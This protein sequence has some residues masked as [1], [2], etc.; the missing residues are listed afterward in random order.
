MSYNARKIEEKWQSYWSE[1]EVYRVLLDESKPKYY[2]LDMFPY[3]SGAGLHVGHP[4]GYIA[5]DIFARYKRHKG[6]NVLHPMGFD[7]F[8]LPAE[9]YAI[10]TGIHPQESTERNIKRYKEQLKSIGFSFDWSREVRTSDPDFYKW[11]QWIFTQMFAHYYD[12][13]EDKAKPLTD[14]I[15]YFDTHGNIGHTAFTEDATAFSAQ[16]WKAFSAAERDERLMDYRLVYR[17]NASVF[18]CEELGTVLSNDEIK[19]G[20]SERGGFPVVKKSMYQWS[21][22]ITAYNE[23]L[24]SGLNTLEWSDALKAM[25]SNWIGKSIGARV[26][27][28]IEQSD[29]VFQV[30]TTRPDTIFGVTFMVLAPEHPL[31]AQITH[32]DAQMEVSTY[33]QE[34]SNRTDRERMTHVKE[35][36]GVNTGA[37]AIHPLTKAKIPIWVADYVLMDY[38]TG[39]IMAVPAEDERDAAFATH[40]DIPIV[41]IL[42]HEE[43]QAERL[44]N[45]DFIDGM[46]VDEAKVAVVDRL[47]EM[48]IGS[49]KI[50]YKLRDANF[51]RQRFW[52]EPF[53]VIYTQD[54]ETTVLDVSQLPLELPEMEDFKPQKDAQSP[55]AKLDQWVQLED[56]AHRETDTMPGFAGSSWYFLRYMDAQNENAFASKKALDYWRDVDLYVGGTEH[57]VGHLLYARFYQKFLFDTG[58]VPTQEPFKK[59]I[60]QGMIRGRSNFIYRANEQFAEQFVADKLKE[61]GFVYQRNYP[62]AGVFADFAL[63]DKKIVIEVKNAHA[64]NHMIKNV[65]PKLRHEGWDIIGISTEHLGHYWNNFDLIIKDINKESSTH[66]HKVLDETEQ[67]IPLYISQDMI[68]DDK[69][70]TALHVDIHLVHDDVLDM[71]AFVEANPDDANALFVTNPSGTYRCGHLVEKMSKSKY[72]VVNPDDVIAQ[73]GADCFRLYEMFLGPIEQSKPWSTSG[74]DGT[75]KFLFKIYSLF[76]DEEDNSLVSDTEPSQDALKILHTCIKKVEEDIQRF[77][78]NTCVS[79]FM[80]CANELKKIKAHNR[81]ILSP[82]C[83]LIAPFAPHLAEELW[84]EALGQAPTVI[85][86]P[87]PEFNPAYLK[88]S[89]IEMPIAINGKT[90]ASH[91]FDA[92]ASQEEIKAEALQVE[93][94]QK[95]I[96]GKEIRK[97]IY[98]PNRMINIVV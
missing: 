97:I 93:A 96:E 66:Q 61:Y 15:A 38:G 62:I 27:F 9:Q 84:S 44:I 58:Y 46:T 51:S 47:E 22:R 10:K 69:L 77:S 25:Q 78:F 70:V 91:V 7:A 80:V 85:D 37:Y 76:F 33:V 57:A 30:F 75:Y 11:T 64:L 87:Y 36:S 72:N 17:R 40:F 52:G 67:P 71:E 29:Q 5:S 55:L 8:G 60:N 49:K 45:S 21:L 98:V 13:K 4:L 31:V 18:W 41:Q 54:G 56:G 89:E 43:G 19:D 23:R 24:L 68:K 26:D 48:Q 63:E 82:L 83:R 3:P 16:E 12:V 92:E 32:P 90:R 65:Q 28:A 86:A 2:V 39:A 35:V 53:P 6:F 1:H 88:S 50:N 20:R 59:L 73:Y 42:T 95:Y 74:I 14:L 81:D 79:A 34:A 94:I